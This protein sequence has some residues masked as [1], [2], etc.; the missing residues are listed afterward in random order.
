MAD[1]RTLF[2]FKLS[3]GE[4]A[5]L[6]AVA[7]DAGRS[8]SEWLRDQIDRAHE[9]LSQG[10]WELGD[11]DAPHEAWTV[12]GEVEGEDQVDELPGPSRPCQTPDCGAELPPGAHHARKYCD[13]CVKARDAKPE[14]LECRI[15][16]RPT[17]GPQKPFCGG[18]HFNLGNPVWLLGKFASLHL[19]KSDPPGTA[20]ASVRDAFKK[21]VRSID[22]APNYS[23][24]EPKTRDGE[25]GS[26]TDYE[27]G[28]GRELRESGY[29]ASRTHVY[30]RLK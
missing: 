3:E 24:L 10:G 7:E 18:C 8:M 26:T 25:G 22:L 27:S 28:Y 6:A 4:K 11:M 30:G 1:A 29:R 23:R 5:R 17:G 15:C 13:A 14:P 19:E 12:E 21:W 2:N 9:R 20:I 16:S